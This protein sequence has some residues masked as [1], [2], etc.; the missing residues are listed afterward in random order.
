MAKVKII[1]DSRSPDGVRLT[2]MELRYPRFI[3]GEFLT[4]RQFARNSASSRAIPFDR[5][6][7]A[8]TNDPVVPLRFGSNKPGMQTGDEIAD[9]AKATKVWLAARA[10]AVAEATKLHRLGVHKSVCNRLLEPWQWMVTVVTAT[11]WDNFFAQRCHE[12]A[13]IHMRTLAEAM[14]AALSASGPVLRQDHA[15]YLTPQD[16]V[17]PWQTRRRLSVARC[18]R[19]SYLQHDGTRDNQK[20][21][22]LHD[23]LRQSMHP[24]PFEHVATAESR[25]H[26]SGPFTGWKQYRKELWPT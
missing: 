7:A 10:K 20:D 23:K 3:H 8:V 11:D 12:D 21:L 22:D 13:E 15:P 5:F 6:V 9:V 17:L 16:S 25:F 19:V 4:H 26:K 24:S 1:L 2:T 14:K 18:A